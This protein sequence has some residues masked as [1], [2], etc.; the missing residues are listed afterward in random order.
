VIHLFPIMKRL[1]LA[2]KILPDDHFLAVYYRLLKKFEQERI[3]WVPPDNMH[4]TLKFFGDTDEEKIVEIR[5]VV[6]KVLKQHKSFWFEVKDIGIFGS[7]YKPRVIWFGTEKADAIMV[8]TK[9]I[10]QHLETIGYENDRQNFV[11]HLTIG[12]IKAL[13]HKK[14]FQEKI[15]LFKGEFIQHVNVS[16]IILFESILTKRGA[17]YEVVNRFPLQ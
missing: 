14:S 5:D 16:E 13:N 11:P 1:F 8:L 9:D 12:R 3:T 10:L 17:I 4:I 15:N 7:S 6:N 2:I